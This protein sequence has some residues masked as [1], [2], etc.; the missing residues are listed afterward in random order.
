VLFPPLTGLEVLQ[1]E[2]DH[3]TLVVVTRLSLNMASLTLEQVLSRR[4]KTLMDMAEGMKSEIRHAFDGHEHEDEL[5]ERGTKILTEAMRHGPLA[6]TPD[7]F[8][9]DEN[10]NHAVSQALGCKQGVVRGVTRLPMKA[11]T[12]NL[13]GWR[14]HHPGRALLLAGWLR[15]MPLVM[16]IDLRECALTPAE[17]RA[18]ASTAERAPKLVAIDV[19]KNETMAE[20]TNGITA[21]AAV[22]ALVKVL[23][24][25]GKLRSLCGVT[26]GNSTLDV[27]RCE[28]PLVDSLLLAA[29]LEASTWIEGIASDQGVRSTCARLMRKGGRD[30]FISWQDGW[31]PLIWAAKDGNTALVNSLLDRGTPIDQMEEEKSSQG[32][33]PLMWA[34]SRGHEATVSLLL[35]RG[36]N[37]RIVERHN[38]NAAMLAEQ[39]GF[40]KI[41]ALIEERMPD[42]ICDVVQRAQMMKKAAEKLH[43]LKDDEPDKVEH[44]ATRVQAITRGKSARNIF[45]DIAAEHA[46][47]PNSHNNGD[48]WGTKAKAAAA[49]AAAESKSYAEGRQAKASTMGGATRSAAS[50]KSV[51]LDVTEESALGDVASRALGVRRAKERLTCLIGARAV[52][53]RATAELSSDKVGEL[54]EGTAVAV[55]DTKAMPDGAIRVAVA[56]LEQPDKLYGWITGAKD[57]GSETLQVTSESASI[58]PGAKQTGAHSLVGLVHSVKRDGAAIEIQRIEKGRSMRA[59]LTA[60]GDHDPHADL[61]SHTSNKS[62]AVSKGAK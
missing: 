13:Q 31:Y 5:A 21:T 54:K 44:A 41:R 9:D 29:E 37:P 6:Q 62:I 39:R 14:M 34:A 1:T 24:G 50:A 61:T 22:E 60:E 28:L 8:N 57:D 4:R 49:A 55:L 59:N 58:L 36:A 33:T 18:L 17:A 2:V 51:T 20:V 30:N 10:F 26:S 12:V 53:V 3:S 35:R 56:L 43:K 42:T 46:H 11:E 47:K 27:P 23:K 7:W 40:A 45:A 38:K 48:D 52:I 32:F 19:R 15:S 25:G 16:S